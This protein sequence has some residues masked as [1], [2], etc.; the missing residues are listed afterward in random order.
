MSYDLDYM[1]DDNLVLEQ[2]SFRN[3]DQLIS[4]L[5]YQ[6]AQFEPTILKLTFPDGEIMD[7]SIGDE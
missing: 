3:K 7:Y 5:I 1:L 6:L 4:E 2:S